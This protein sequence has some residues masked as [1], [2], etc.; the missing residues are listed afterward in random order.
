MTIQVSFNATG[1]TQYM[2]GESH[3][4]TM[5]LK[6]TYISLEQKII[7]LTQ[8]ICRSVRL[9]LEFKHFYKTNLCSCL[10]D[11]SDGLFWADGL[12]IQEHSKTES[13]FCL[14]KSKKFIV[15]V[16]PAIGEEHT[17]LFVIKTK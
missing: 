7:L 15:I 3:L 8:V 14:D 1:G 17:H 13:K 10:D 4:Y 6:L 12:H 9:E 2:E 16:K 11:D 5:P